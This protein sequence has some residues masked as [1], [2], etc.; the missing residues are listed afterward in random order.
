MKSLN[1][2]TIQMKTAVFSLD[3]VYAVQDGPN[4]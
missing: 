4:F 2:V 1:G 3:A